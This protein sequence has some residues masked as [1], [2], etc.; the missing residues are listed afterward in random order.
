MCIA[1]NVENFYILFLLAF[2]AFWFAQKT[3]V[4]TAEAAA[5]RVLSNKLQNKGVSLT[6]SRVETNRGEHFGALRVR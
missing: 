3:R 6:N 2:L 1:C 4:R 5:N